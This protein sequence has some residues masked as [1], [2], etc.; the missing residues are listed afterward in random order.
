MLSPDQRELFLEALRPPDGYQFDRGIGT[1]FTLDLLTLLIAPLSLTLLEVE[2]AEEALHDP[3]I[4]LEGVRSH[5]ERL[6]IFCQAGRIAIPR[7]DSCLYHLLEQSIVEVQAPFGGVF[8]PKV[9]LLRYVQEKEEEQE[10]SL[11]PLYRLLNLTRNLTF[12]TSW[13][14]MLRLEGYLATERQLAYAR[15]HPLGDF[16]EQLPEIAR[17]PPTPRVLQDVELLQAEVRRVD[18]RPPE[19]FDRDHLAFYPAGLPGHRAYRFYDR[20]DRALV[21]SPFLSDRMLR[22]ITEGG[23]D[24]VLISRPD[25]I[26]ALKPETRALFDKIYVLQ[27]MG[28]A[29]EEENTVEDVGEAVAGARSEP[30]GL[31]A[32]LFVVE[33]GW[34]ATW[35][36]GSSN[37]T[38]PAFFRGDQNVEFL[39]ELKGKKSKIGIDEILGEE[40]DNDLFSL[41]YPYSHQDVEEEADESEK[42]AEELA[43]AVRDWLLTLDM[44]LAVEEREEDVFDLTLRVPPA[45]HE[46][47]AGEVTVD[48]WP[49]SL[50]SE[51]S[52]NL[53]LSSGLLIFSEISRLALTSFI[54]FQIAASVNGSRY[55]LRFVLNLPIEGLPENRKE[56]IFCAILSDQAQFL[57]YL[58]I[59]LADRDDVS[60]YW[61]N[62][63]DDESPGQ[64]RMGLDA[65]MPLLK[66][67]V[68]ALSRSPEKI[69]RIAEIV[70]GLQKT[71]KGHEVLPEDFEM[72][73][74]AVIESRGEI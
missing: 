65:D 67:L 1:T 24:H 23:E 15:N 70:A 21:I 43:N 6:T 26:G 9:W 32:K 72:L 44:S 13:D 29:E 69:D 34:D 28:S 42:R 62:S 41:L 16:I 12:D 59:L 53:P 22:R 38:N 56:H 68:L 3:V 36:I 33:A 35:A 74:Q 63:L 61:T 31:H 17:H 73:W 5:A 54:A 51:R 49:V 64:W 48:C 2:D 45:A 8:H 27:D 57:R 37:A 71:P 11:P 50:Q 4:M 7:K 14:L 47:P 58:R 19:P 60:A 52:Q 25:S 66:G 20:C 46:T 10:A 39:V 40:K 18:F 55:K 30:M